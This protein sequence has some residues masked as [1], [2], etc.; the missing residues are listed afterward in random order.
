[1]Q[2]LRPLPRGRTTNRSTNNI[3]KYTE[4]RNKT[5]TH[6]SVARNISK[7]LPCT[8]R[9]ALNSRGAQNLVA[10]V[11]FGTRE[12]NGEN[13]KAACD[14]YR[15]DWGPSWSSSWD[16]RRYKHLGWQQIPVCILTIQDQRPHSSFVHNTISDPSLAKEQGSPRSSSSGASRHRFLGTLRWQFVCLTI[17]RSCLFNL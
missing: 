11:M 15:S 14:W 16:P 4:Y 5:E 13:C 17:N 2:I 7:R 1:M 6:S 12:E 9:L 3:H 10:C 8:G